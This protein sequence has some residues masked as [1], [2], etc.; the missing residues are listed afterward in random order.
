MNFAFKEKLKK[1]P[2]PVVISCGAVVLALL[3]GFGAYQ[4][5]YLFKPTVIKGIDASHY[6]GDISWRA[7]AEN[8]GAHFVYLKATEGSTFK[9]PDF[10]RNL[11]GA[12]EN[13]IP[14]G[15]YHYFTQTSTGYDQALNFI[16]TVPKR[17]GELPPAIDIEGNVAREKDFK[18]QLATYVR[19][20]KAHYNQKPVFYVTYQVYDMLY[21]D[22]AGYNFWIITSTANRTSRAGLSGSIPTKA[23]SPASTAM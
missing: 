5:G 21:D 17:K 19:T 11:R 9:D 3:V 20:I 12:T 23:K 14:A 13:K 18:A 6:Q 4:I 1:I 10:S 2:K 8:G 16:A 7:I 22:Y 15:G